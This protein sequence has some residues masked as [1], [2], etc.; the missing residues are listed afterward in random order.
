MIAW[1]RFVL[2]NK[3]GRIDEE[4]P[5]LYR[6]R[7]LIVVFVK[8]PPQISPILSQISSLNI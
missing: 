1:K 4:V 2:E 3:K 5:A 6:T 8:N 7:R